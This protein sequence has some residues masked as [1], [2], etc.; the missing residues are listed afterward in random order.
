MKSVATDSPRTAR[1]ADDRNL[2]RPAPS[3]PILLSNGSY[4][5]QLS[6]VGSGFS[7]VDGVAVTRW[8]GDEL[9]D[10]DGF[11]I[12]IRDLDDG[13][14][15][16]AGYQPTRVVPTRYSVQSD[17]QVAEISR[18]DREIDCRLT[19]SVAA[20]HPFEI[21]RCQLT[22]LS[23]HRRRLELTSYLEWVLT[24]QAADRTH[25][26]FSKWFI[27]T[28]FCTDRQ[29]ILARRRPRGSDENEFWGFHSVLSDESR[30]VNLGGQFET[31]RA[32][33]IGRGRTL[34]S[35]S[36][37]DERAKLSGE[38]GPVLDPIASVRTALSL[39]PGQSGEV[40]FVLG[41]T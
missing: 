2:L 9:F 29:A 20:E 38:T 7:E 36:A 41:A 10:S 35:P 37:L 19:V 16:S 18:V 8:S 25:P 24:S 13:Y 32:R 27:D 14:V 21:R 28:Q 34:H 22:N 15:W 40:R 5:L 1:W 39:D 30:A 26:A 23:K 31:N 3:Q 33:F 11:Y 4:K 17:G 12:Y 6:E